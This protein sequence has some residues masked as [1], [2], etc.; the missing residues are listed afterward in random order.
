[1]HII[2]VLLSIFSL[3]GGAHVCMQAYAH[4]YLCPSAIWDSTL[5][6]KKLLE[7]VRTISCTIILNPH[8]YSFFLFKGGAIHASLDEW[9]I[10]VEAILLKFSS[11]G[12]ACSILPCDPLSVMLCDTARNRSFCKNITD[13]LLLGIVPF[14]ILNWL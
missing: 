14:R 2:D 1:M 5:K 10:I 13:T 4:V 7:F 6:I 12:H 8:T 11:L 9:P 3:E